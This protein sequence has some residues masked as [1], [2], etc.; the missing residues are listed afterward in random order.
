MCGV[1][2]VRVR[3]EG[4]DAG[5]E[6]SLVIVLVVEASRALLCALRGTFSRSGL[7]SSLLGASAGNAIR[8]VVIGGW[9]DGEM[10]GISAE[11][12]PGK[13]KTSVFVFAVP[14]PRTGHSGLM[15]P[16]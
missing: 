10:G 1:V 9:G 7:V 5:L 12:R 13:N 6:G 14:D 8:I 4:G 11:E 16:R 2:E 15:E 3:S